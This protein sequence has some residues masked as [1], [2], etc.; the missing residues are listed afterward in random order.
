MTSRIP[1]LLRALA[2]EFEA[3]ANPRP[4]SVRRKPIVSQPKPRTKPTELQQARADRI[5]RSKGLIP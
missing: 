5:L 4:H 1:I 3:L 2:D